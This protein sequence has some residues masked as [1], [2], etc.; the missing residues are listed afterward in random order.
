[1]IDLKNSKN[2]VAYLRRNPTSAAMQAAADLIEE[3]ENKLCKE[4]KRAKELGE[5]SVSKGHTR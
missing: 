2:L 3:L 5:L 4:K 1:M